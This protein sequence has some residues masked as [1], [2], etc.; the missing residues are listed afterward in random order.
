ML[1]AIAGLLT[2][3]VSSQFGPMAFIGLVLPQLA[4]QLGARDTG[5][6]LALAAVLGAS[7]LS[8]ADL[9][10]RTLIYPAQ[11]PTGALAS[12]LC[13]FLLLASLLGQA[14]RLP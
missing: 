1:L 8:L 7:L 4:Q 5:Q 2:L 11:I 10:S 6:Q 9:A 12:L 3:I 13:G 14:R